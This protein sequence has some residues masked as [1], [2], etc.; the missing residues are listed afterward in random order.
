MLP[1]HPRM[2]LQR[3]WIRAVHRGDDAAVAQILAEEPV[4]S[5]VDTALQEAAMSG[6]DKVVAQ[7]L[8]VANPRIADAKGCTAL[9]YAVDSGHERVVEQLLAVSNLEM[10]TNTD[11]GGNVIHLAARRNHIKIMEQ[12]LAV[13]PTAVVGAFD[14]HHST[15]LHEAAKSGHDEIVELLLAACPSLIDE[16]DRRNRTALHYAVIMATRKWRSV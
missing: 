16:L 10:Q 15:A 6:H 14:D 12:L 8:T 1:M 4:M 7:L 13:A 9:H 3:K 2:V 11:Q 5:D